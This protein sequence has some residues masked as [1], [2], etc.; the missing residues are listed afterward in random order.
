MIIT[1]NT[2]KNIEQ[3]N[4]LQQQLR[5]L[6]SIFL[7][8]VGC[9]LTSWPLVK[10]EASITFSEDICTV[11]NPTPLFSVLFLGELT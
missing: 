2:R 8:I 3:M 5:T 4:A 10:T 7:L 9:G 1:M 6:P 11:D